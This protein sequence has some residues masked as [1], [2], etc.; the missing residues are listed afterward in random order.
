M[1]TSRG[2][3]LVKFDRDYTNLLREDFLLRIDEC[4][5][6]EVALVAAH[7]EVT[8][9]LTSRAQATQQRVQSLLPFGA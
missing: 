4:N 2:N 1:H 7:A 6:V 5:I 8:L 3:I 9:V